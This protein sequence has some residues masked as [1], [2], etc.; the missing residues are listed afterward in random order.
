[1]DKLMPTIEGLNRE[2]LRG[3]ERYDAMVQ[4][5]DEQRHDAM[6][7]EVPSVRLCKDCRHFVGDSCYTQRNRA[8]DYVNG[9]SSPRNSPAFL[10]E[11]ESRC[12]PGGIWWE[13]K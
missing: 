10:R 2:A 8:F 4:R 11:F 1:M 13:A 5:R 7:Q 12:G 6:V 3:D 9:G